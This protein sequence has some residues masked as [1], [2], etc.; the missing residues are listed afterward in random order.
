MVTVVPDAAV[1][2]AGALPEPPLRSK[3]SVYLV[4]DAAFHTACRVVSFVSVIT[5]PLL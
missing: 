1:I 5:E 3:E 4:T 2:L